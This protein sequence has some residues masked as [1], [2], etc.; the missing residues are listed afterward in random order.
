M[1]YI[2]VSFLIFMFSLCIWG[3]ICN[4][5][6]SDQRRDILFDV[7][8]KAR[9]SISSGDF[10]WRRFHEVF[11]EVSYDRHFWTLFIMR[12]PLKLYRDVQ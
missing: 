10:N 5:K 8:K 4:S 9:A 12:D 3:Q 6:T 11:D 1:D 7:H 2:F